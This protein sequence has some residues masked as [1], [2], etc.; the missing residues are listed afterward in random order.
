MPSSGLQDKQV[1]QSCVCV[2]KE[3][4]TSKE[5]SKWTGLDQRLS[6]WPPCPVSM[7]CCHAIPAFF[8]FLYSSVL[9]PSFLFLSVAFF[10]P[11]LSSSFLLCLIHLFFSTATHLVL[12]K[13]FLSLSNASVP[14]P[15]IQDANLDRFLG[16]GGQGAW[17]RLWGT[18]IIKYLIRECMFC[19]IKVPRRTHKRV[20][21]QLNVPLCCSWIKLNECSWFVFI[22]FT[23]RKFLR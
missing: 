10:Y 18:G 21:T 13:S 19:K 5:E 3:Q 8:P 6:T 23:L 9:G 1:Q 12:P 11:F 7:S 16:W 17:E 22:I 15:C 20:K 14:T 4:P 2:Y